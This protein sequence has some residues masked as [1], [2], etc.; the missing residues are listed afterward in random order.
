[1][2]H[3]VSRPRGIG[4]NGVLYGTDLKTN[5][6]KKSCPNRV[7]VRM[8]DPVQKKDP[9]LV[10]IGIRKIHTSQKDP[11]QKLDP[12]QLDRIDFWSPFLAEFCFAVGTIHTHPHSVADA[13][14]SQSKETSTIIGEGERAATIMYK[15]RRA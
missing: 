2:C 3:G 13:T 4:T 8:P 5:V 15:R 9:V 7:A 14:Q 1:M 10:Y 11:V 12:V 6:T